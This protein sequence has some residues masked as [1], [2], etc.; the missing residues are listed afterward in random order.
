MRLSHHFTRFA[1]LAL[2]ALLAAPGLLAQTGYTVT[3][4]NDSGEGSL[5]EGVAQG[6]TNI[7]F[8]VQGAGVIMLQS[9]LVVNTPCAIDGLGLITLSGN[10][11]FLLVDNHAATQISGV[12]FTNAGDLGG[13]RGAVCN[14]TGASLTLTGCYFSNNDIGGFYNDV[15]GKAI[16]DRCTFSSCGTVNMNGGA[17][18]NA[19]TLSVIYCLFTNNTATLGGAIYNDWYVSGDQVICGFLFIT[20]DGTNPSVFSGNT[21]TSGGAIYNNGYTDA[22]G[23]IFNPAKITPTQNSDLPHQGGQIAISGAAFTS[24]KTMDLGEGGAFLGGAIYSVNGE[25]N[26]ADAVFS[27]NTAVSGGGM[28]VVSGLVNLED[29][30]FDANQASNGS[31]GALSANS[32]NTTVYALN[33]WFTNNNSTIGGGAVGLAQLDGLTNTPLL[34]LNNC[35][36]TGNTVGVPS[37]AGSGLQAGGILWQT[38]ASLIINSTFASNTSNQTSGGSAG[39]LICGRFSQL[40]SCHFDKNT[41]NVSGSDGSP[42]IFAA[43]GAAYYDGQIQGP[44]YSCRVIGSLFTNNAANGST[45]W[46]TAG[47]MLIIPVCDPN[48]S[49]ENG[50]FPPYSPFQVHLVGMVSQSLFQG[51][52]SLGAATNGAG[53]LNMYCSDYSF[54]SNCLI[55]GTQASQGNTA[56]TSYGGA[57]LQNGTCD[58]AGLAVHSTGLNSTF[59][60]SNNIIAYNQCNDTTTSYL[61]SAGGVISSYTNQMTFVN[62]IIA[63]NNNVCPAGDTPGIT[64]SA[65]ALS[66]HDGA[67]FLTG[68]TIYGNTSTNHYTGDSINPTI[69]LINE[70]V[71]AT[72]LGNYIG[73][74]GEARSQGKTNNMDSDYSDES[75]YNVTSSGYNVYDTEATDDGNDIWVSTDV[76]TSVDLIPDSAFTFPGGIPFPVLMPAASGALRHSGAP[77]Q[78]FPNTDARNFLRPTGSF[79]SGACD[80]NATQR[81][82][83]NITCKLSNGVASV[84]I[85][86]SPLQLVNFNP[87]AATSPVQGSSGIFVSVGD[88]LVIAPPP[89]SFT[90]SK[91]VWTSTGTCGTN[92]QSSYTLTFDTNAQ[93]WSMS[94]Q[95]IPLTVESYTF[96]G[97]ENGQSFNKTINGFMVA[98]YIDTQTY[99]DFY[100]TSGSPSSSSPQS[101]AVAPGAATAKKTI[102]HEKVSWR[103]DAK[104]HKKFY[105]THTLAK[106]LNSFDV[107]KGAGSFDALGNGRD[108]IALSGTFNP[109]DGK[110]SLDDFEQSGSVAVTIGFKQYSFPVKSFVNKKKGVYNLT[111]KARNLSMALDFNKL[112][113]NFSAKKDTMPWASPYKG[114][115]LSLDIGSYQGKCHLVPDYKGTVK[116]VKTKKQ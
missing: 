39:G 11:G 49:T 54:V 48:S 16:L 66:V 35:H 80:P 51:N 26:I 77:P 79:T 103:F 22:T 29:C 106:P 21:A 60:V 27:Q 4:L 30:G 64:F 58:A 61:F 5:R 81:A 93:T 7:S 14:N 62:N 73:M 36:V 47:G 84:S 115:V 100:V 91:G 20:G 12:A 3:N 53:G 44:V 13:I 23:N 102:Q 83:Q 105:L 78:G 109:P 43:G 95:N 107:T 28:Y 86:N 38:G 34:W 24:N 87:P 70:G 37:S 50:E 88:S 82:I 17:V 15:G 56:Q 55:G 52:S 101:M 8:A 68:N 57:W 112:T 110:L 25:F 92:N 2:L 33:S 59:I 89:S 108:A 75:G 32:A 94:A 63:F 45:S 99:S 19:G 6:A 46:H 74:N 116:P 69:N 18:Y 90:Q 111:D 1:T 41:A 65:L 9:T 71:T 76:S 67:T 114:V 42:A 96:A 97:S 31:G 40:L 85:Q 104:K 72:L 113:W 10:G 98:L